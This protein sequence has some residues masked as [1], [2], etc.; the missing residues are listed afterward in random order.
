MP[1]PSETMAKANVLLLFRAGAAGAGTIAGGAGGVGVAGAGNAGCGALVGGWDQ[2][3]SLEGSLVGGSGM[4][5]T[6][7][8]LT[9][10]PILPGCGLLPAAESAKWANAMRA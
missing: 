10:G 1:I 3:S 6:N 7:D 9:A 2:S 8:S 5:L 4:V